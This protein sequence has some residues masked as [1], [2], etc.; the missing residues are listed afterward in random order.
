MAVGIRIEFFLS[1]WTA[2]RQ[3]RRDPRDT[4]KFYNVRHRRENDGRRLRVSAEGGENHRND[5]ALWTG[6]DHRD[7]HLKI[8][9]KSQT[10][11]LAPDTD[12]QYDVMLF[13]HRLLTASANGGGSETV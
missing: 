1:G 8:D 2:A 6:G 10:E 5:R 11:R 12:Q 7:D 9:H 3:R 4:E 13:R